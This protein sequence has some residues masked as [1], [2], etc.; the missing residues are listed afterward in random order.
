MK[1]DLYQDAIVAQAKQATR[2]GRLEAPDAS[3]TLDNPLCGDRVTIDVKLAGDRIVDMAHRVRG[4]LLCEASASV[5][6]ANAV[7]QTAGKLTAAERNVRAMLDGTS[8]GDALWPGVE[9]FAPV[10]AYKS[11]HACVLLPLEALLKA[12]RTARTGGSE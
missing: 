9:A 3:I 2:A 11:R 12:I 4:C 5:I 10:A 1:A 6:G 7:G 8:T